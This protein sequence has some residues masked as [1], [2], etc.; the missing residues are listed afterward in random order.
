MKN[1]YFW[2]KVLKAI[3]SGLCINE[4]ISFKKKRNVFRFRIFKFTVT[5]AIKINH[6]HCKKDSNFIFNVY[7]V[8]H[9]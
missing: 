9:L 1:Y 3:S 8:T 7:T 6:F 2:A 5:Q 4:T